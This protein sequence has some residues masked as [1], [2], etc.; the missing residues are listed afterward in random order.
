MSF[1]E[2]ETAVMHWVGLILAIVL[3]LMLV[4]GNAVRTAILANSMDNFTN[5]KKVQEKNYLLIKRQLLV[6]GALLVISL[7]II[8]LVPADRPLAYAALGLL[9][10]FWGKFFPS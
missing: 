3:S 5:P 4:P 8:L 1:G 10:G 2:T 7:G 6:S 9:V